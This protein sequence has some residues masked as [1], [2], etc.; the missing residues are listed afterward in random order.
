MTFFVT[1]NILTA[2]WQ[3]NRLKSWP[4]SCSFILM[5][6]SKLILSLF[7]ISALSLIGCKNE[8]RPA[9]QSLKPLN[10]EQAEAERTETEQEE[11]QAQQPRQQQPIMHP[12]LS[13]LSEASKAFLAET[14]QRIRESR[15]IRRQEI[16]SELHI[17]DSM[18]E[19]SNPKLE[20]DGSKIFYS[21]DLEFNGQTS[22]IRFESPDDYEREFLFKY[23]SGFD[24]KPIQLQGMCLDFPNCKWLAVQVA[25]IFERTKITKQFVIDERTEEDLAEEAAR[26][27]E[28]DEEP[29]LEEGP[30]VQTEIIGLSPSTN[31]EESLP[32]LPSSEQPARRAQSPQQ[33][34][35]P[36]S[37]HD[38]APT[39]IDLEI[40]AEEVTST[41]PQQPTVPSL[42]ETTPTASPS[43]RSE[44][45]P[46]QRQAPSLA[47]PNP[48]SEK[49]PTVDASS[50]QVNVE[51][52]Q[53]NAPAQP[54]V[55][56][57]LPAQPSGEDSPVQRQAPS[58]ATPNPHS[59]RLPIESTPPAQPNAEDPSLSATDQLPTEAVVR[60]T[61]APAAPSKPIV[62]AELPHIE[63]GTDPSLSDDQRT[64][65]KLPTPNAETLEPLQAADEAPKSPSVGE[66]VAQ[67]EAPSSES[68][69]PSLAQSISPAVNRDAPQLPSPDVADTPPARQDPPT[70]PSLDQEPEALAELETPETE[71][72]DLSYGELNED[73]VALVTGAEEGFVF[74]DLEPA[75]D[76]DQVFNVDNAQ[77]VL[78][79]EEEDPNEILDEKL[80][81]IKTKSFAQARGFYANSTGSLVNAERMRENQRSL[82]FINGDE[83]RRRQYSSGLTKLAIEYATE[84]IA[85]DYPG[86]VVCGHD[87]SKRTG[88][89]LGGHTSHRNGLDLDVS[90]PTSALTESQCDNGSGFQ[91]WRQYR[92][93][94]SDFLKKNWEFVN[95][96]LDTERVHVIFVDRQMI[97]A[98]CT[99][100]KNNVRIERSERSRIFKKLHHIGNHHHHYHIRMKC[101]QQN[102]GCTPQGELTGST[103]R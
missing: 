96:L 12:D 55:D 64:A 91:S 82:F 59:E 2:F 5:K 86:T 101:N 74:S 79:A 73:N 34:A 81:L 92:N 21:L 49:A 78:V 15:D 90:F 23:V 9:D 53:L 44:D 66:Q 71:T 61:S 20:R 25:Y 3:L 94:D 43:S 72:P 54:S 85:A 40:V 65:P 28:L 87:A 33:L 47:T 83:R 42:S 24:E 89:R 102:S 22:E 63:G 84:K 100:V 58:L 8:S 95:H 67:P 50:P 11:A 46:V 10:V 37:T 52:P 57:N 19:F 70:A 17:Q 16:I 93:R 1:L 32:I 29:I 6:K 98:L 7:V 48:H 68:A 26:Q 99:Y 27:K 76:H 45:S 62:D 88:G 18:I 30:N 56:T 13:Q 41:A 39:P 97:S 35:A 77:L 36:D 75:K 60:D 69:A 4:R 14:E 51:S 103:C 80:R 38:S 31:Q